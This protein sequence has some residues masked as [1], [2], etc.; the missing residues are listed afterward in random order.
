MAALPQHRGE[1]RG[2]GIKPA[3]VV[4]QPGVDLV[5]AE[6]GLHGRYIQRPG[7]VG[8]S[9]WKHQIQ[10]SR[11]RALGFGEGRIIRYETICHENTKRANLHF[12]S[13]WPVLRQEF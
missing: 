4:Q 5:V 9:L 2:N 10:Y 1:V 12:P 3:E 7:L 13:S 11:L 6:R 8:D